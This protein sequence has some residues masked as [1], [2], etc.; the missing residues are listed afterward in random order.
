MVGVKEYSET[1]AG[2]GVVEVVD[3]AFPHV[4]PSEAQKYIVSSVSSLE[5]AKQE[6]DEMDGCH[7]NCN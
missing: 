6:M 2:E 4:A 1:F 3:K 7:C 5:A